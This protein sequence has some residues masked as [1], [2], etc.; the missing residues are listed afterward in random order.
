MGNYDELL[1]EADTVHISGRGRELLKWINDALVVRPSEGEL[2]VAKAI[3]HNRLGEHAECVTIIEKFKS[4]NHIGGS[5]FELAV[6]YAGLGNW[7]E[8]VK[9]VDLLEEKRILFLEWC[10]NMLEEEFETEFSA[11]VASIW[12][13]IDPNAYMPYISLAWRAARANDYE[14]AAYNYETAIELGAD[15]DPYDG[16]YC[17]YGLAW[18]RA[19]QHRFT[20]AVGILTGFIKEDET[21]LTTT[22]LEDMVQLLLEYKQ[23]ELALEIC[24]SWVRYHGDSRSHL[25]HGEV[26]IGLL[27]HEEAVSSLGWCVGDPDTSSDAYYQIGRA[28]LF[29]GLH[30]EA[31]ECWH[32]AVLLGNRQAQRSLELVSSSD[33]RTHAVPQS[34]Q[35]EAK[36]AQPLDLDDDPLIL[37][38]AATKN[39]PNIFRQIPDHW[40]IRYQGSEPFTIRNYRGLQ[41]IAVLLRSPHKPFRASEL[42]LGLSKS[43]EID[44]APPELDQEDQDEQS[45]ERRVQTSL[46]RPKASKAT[47]SDYKKGLNVLEEKL[48]EAE[49]L[50]EKEEIEQKIKEIKNMMIAD[51]YSESNPDDVKNANSVRNAVNR[52]VERLRQTDQ[53]L[54]K[55]LENCIDFGLRVSYRPPT[56]I[57]WNTL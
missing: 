52:A 19:N 37:G 28:K 51:S 21:P 39:S 34:R 54:A 56:P 4:E 47:Q 41:F 16:V 2:L 11:S 31:I 24:E 30:S 36:K 42:V 43:V 55:H 35:A 33:N 49:S 53:K 45:Q 3:I 13:K 23:N 29:L 7:N 12:V 27:R 17:R 50:E 6:A 25:R 40:I 10:H 46:R 18:V 20:D 38:E 14:S 32:K 22:R 9:N 1:L 5:S 8:A 44:Q 26:L 15:D 57:E 48:E